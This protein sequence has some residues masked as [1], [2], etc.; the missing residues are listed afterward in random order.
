MNLI[1]SQEGR[2]IAHT[3]IGKLQLSQSTLDVQLTR[4]VCSSRQRHLC[5][6]T[7]TSHKT[8]NTQPCVQARRPSIK[9]HCNL[10]ATE[11]VCVAQQSAGSVAQ[12]SGAAARQVRSTVAGRSQ[13]RA[14]APDG[15]PRAGSELP[16]RAS[17]IRHSD[18]IH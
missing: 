9:K 5:S 18:V 11:Q 14:A 3:V 7:R 17:I 16:K 13:G 1:C 2:G 8:R 4:K 6:A 15:A 12:H 10:R